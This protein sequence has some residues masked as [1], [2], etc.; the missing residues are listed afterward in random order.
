[1]FKKYNAKNTTFEVTT[2]QILKWKYDIGGSISYSGS[3]FS[4][5][6]KIKNLQ[7]LSV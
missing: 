3:I 1:M 5:T 7:F 2:A 4:R 6:S